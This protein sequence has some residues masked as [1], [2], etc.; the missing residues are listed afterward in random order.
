[1]MAGLFFMG[2]STLRTWNWER[3]HCH[4]RSLVAS[5]KRVYNNKLAAVPVHGNVQ[6]AEASKKELFSNLQ[7]FAGPLGKLS[8]LEMGCSTIFKFYPPR[9]RVTCVEPNSNFEKFFFK[10]V[11]ENE[12]Q[13]F[14]RFVV[15]ARDNMHQ[16]ADGS[17][18]VVVCTLVLCSVKN[19][20]ILRQV[21]RVLRSGGTFYF[22]EHMVDERSTWNYFWQQVLDPDWYLLL[23]GRNLTQESWKA[24][25]QASFSKLKVQ[26]ILDFGEGK[27]VTAAAGVEASP[28]EVGDLAGY[29]TFEK[30]QTLRGIYCFEGAVFSHYKL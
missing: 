8:L 28:L 19:Q 26:H 6:E 16:V 15:A 10:S 18:E 27:A 25:E 21:C 4:F 9:C 2:L 24:L 3:Q 30:N 14:K 12:Q 1:K 13:Q 11:S 17:V 22:M 5:F 20:K 7:E 29:S 23:Q